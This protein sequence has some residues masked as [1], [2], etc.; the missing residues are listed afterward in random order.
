MTVRTTLE[1]SPDGLE[2]VRM[3]SSGVVSAEE[4]RGFIARV[5]P[6][7][8]LTGRPI[9]AVMEGKVDLHPEARKAYG[10][11][12]KTD[13]EKPRAVAVVTANA[14]LRVMLSFVLR[15]TGSGDH[16]KFFGNEPDALAWLRAAHAP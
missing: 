9:L 12:G 1:K 13:V 6:G 2:Y 8:D 5:L 7:G 11:M 4:A 3:V 14:P 10:A 15:I 16:T